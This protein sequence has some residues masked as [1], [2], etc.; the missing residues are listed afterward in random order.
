[1][2]DDFMEMIFQQ[3]GL[4]GAV[5]SGIAYLPQ[6]LHMFREKCTNGLSLRAYGLWTV[7]SLMVF[8]H[9][10]TVGDLVFIALGTIQI[11]A[12]IIIAVYTATHKDAVCAYHASKMIK[13]N[14]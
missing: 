10:V 13:D 1:V 2:Y 14:I 4:I 9:A 12:T 11:T 3:I 6:I 7:S 8:A 5:I